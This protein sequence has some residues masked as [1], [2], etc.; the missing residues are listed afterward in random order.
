MTSATPRQRPNVVL[1]GFMGTGKST[2]GRILAERLG[3][4]FMDTDAF[5]EHI[6]GPIA[7]I[8]AEQG[9]ETFRLLERGAA[10][11][12]G[13]DDGQVIATGGRMALD[14]NNA[15]ALQ[16]NGKIVCL[17]ATIDEIYARVTADTDGPD[18]PLLSGEDPFGQIAN[19]LAERADA[20]AKFP[21]V[22]TSGRT[23]D[24]VADAVLSAIKLSSN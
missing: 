1:T 23:P 8:F 10:A 16:A 17:T 13:G 15:A 19:L 7:T 21:Q 5:I 11:M 18:R 3:Y 4:E 9:E 22:N 20:Y 2:V 12:L 6:H 14:P 24:E